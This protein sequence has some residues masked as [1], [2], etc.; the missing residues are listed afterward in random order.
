MMHLYAALLS[1]PVV[2]TGTIRTL[3]R[4]IHNVENLVITDDDRLFVTGRGGVHEFAEAS[5]RCERRLVPVDCPGLPASCMKNGIAVHGDHLY[6][7]CA[8]VFQGAA[9]FASA[10]LPDVNRLEQDLSGLLRLSLA[11]LPRAVQS[12][13][14]RCDLTR[15][16]LAFSAWADLP[17]GVLANGIAVDADGGFPRRTVLRGQRPASAG[18]RSMTTRAQNSGTVRLGGSRT[19]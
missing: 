4:G 6:L 9:P 15:R 16:D 3:G 17:S 1:R 8:H 7:A 14:V 2:L 11:T 5:G 12:W 18:C 13:V 10:V 19:A